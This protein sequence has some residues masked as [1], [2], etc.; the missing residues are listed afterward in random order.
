MTEENDSVISL[1]KTPTP[2]RIDID[3][4]LLAKEEQKEVVQSAHKLKGV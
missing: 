4:E 3:A 1:F 2:V